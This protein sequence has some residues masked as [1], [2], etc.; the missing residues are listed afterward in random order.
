VIEALTYRQ[1]GHSRADPAKYRPQEEV[2]A[3]L[4]RDPLTLLAEKLHAGG[5]A[6]Q[7]VEERRARAQVLVAA[8]VEAAKAAPPADEASA[9]TDVWADGG[10]QWR[11]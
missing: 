9:F 6:Q 11:T 4:R 7:D 3:W 1:Y 2:D 8:A 10:A 5:V